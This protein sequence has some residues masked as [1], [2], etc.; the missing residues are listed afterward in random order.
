MPLFFGNDKTCCAT[1]RNHKSRKTPRSASIF[2]A[3]KNAKKVHF[4]DFF[5]KC[6][7]PAVFALFVNLTAFLP[8]I[9]D[10]KK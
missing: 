9:F 2:F 3:S 6:K 1:R 4:F 5:E 7:K 8:L 10:L